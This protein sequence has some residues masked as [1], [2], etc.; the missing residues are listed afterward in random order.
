VKL[1]PSPP[2]F[3][4]PPT[5][6]STVKASPV[7]VDSAAAQRVTTAFGDNVVM[8]LGPAPKPAVGYR[9]RETDSRAL[10]DTTSCLVCEEPFTFDEPLIKT[11]CCGIDIHE[12]CNHYELEGSGKCR[13]CGQ[14]EAKQEDH[15]LEALTED[16]SYIHHFCKDPKAAP[17]SSLKSEEFG[18]LEEC[19]SHL[20]L[21]DD[22]M[23]QSDL[24]SSPSSFRAQRSSTPSTWLSSENEFPAVNSQSEAEGLHGGI[25]SDEVQIEAAMDELVQAKDRFL[26][27]W[28]KKK[29]E[30][31]EEDRIKIVQEIVFSSGGK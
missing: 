16:G 15:S 23:S 28:L 13:G 29:G 10:L 2:S 14:Q 30:V 5:P 4:S 22:T 20:V 8:L 24:R 7:P 11:P 18:V 26:Q 25:E 31:G 19:G 21:S 6:E 3:V 12:L 1:P 17:A 9:D 27:A